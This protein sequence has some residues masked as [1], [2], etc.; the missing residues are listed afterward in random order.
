ML[1]AY[2]LI[3]KYYNHDLARTLKQLE[4]E[5]ADSPN[6]LR[7]LIAAE[8]DVGLA[9]LLNRK[10]WLSTFRLRGKAPTPA[11]T[12]D[13]LTAAIGRAFDGLAPALEQWVD[14]E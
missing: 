5:L 7:A 8:D 3:Q 6:Q 11:P 12:S 1:T 13:P 2:P 9:R 10:A 4:E 14:V